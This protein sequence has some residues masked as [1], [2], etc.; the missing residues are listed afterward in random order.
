MRTPVTR[1]RSSHLNALLFDHP[2][3]HNNN[4]GCI[5]N[6]IPGS[7]IWPHQQDLNR[8]SWEPISEHV[9]HIQRWRDGPRPSRNKQ[10]MS[11]PKFS[12]LAFANTCSHMDCPHMSQQRHTVLRVGMMSEEGIREPHLLCVQKITK[13]YD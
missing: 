2:T 4:T 1:S 10:H 12:P 8:P 6:H 5:F 11:A 9:G 3:N 7:T 13:I